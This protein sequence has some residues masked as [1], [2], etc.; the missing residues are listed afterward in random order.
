MFSTVY[1]RFRNY[2]NTGAVFVSENTVPLLFP[3]KNCESKSGGVFRRLFPTVFIPSLSPQGPPRRP[4]GGGLGATQHP[5]PPAP[6]AAVGGDRPGGGGGGW[7]TSQSRF[8]HR[9]QPPAAG[10]R[11]SRAG[12]GIPFAGSGLLRR[13]WPGAGPPLASSSV[14]GAPS[15]FSVRGRRPFLLGARGFRGRGSLAGCGCVRPA[16]HPG[17]GAGS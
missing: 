9:R 14:A 8:S 16:S 13:G 7:R 17:C 5:L 4:P 1:F 11:P 2:R 3:I 6:Q 10:R 12:S 15:F